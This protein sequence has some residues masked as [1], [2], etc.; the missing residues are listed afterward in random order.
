MVKPKLYSSGSRITWQHFHIDGTMSVR[1]GV[2]WDR[3]PDLDGQ[4]MVCWVVP[5]EAM[6]A[7]FY[8]LIAVGRATRV[9]VH[10]HGPFRQGPS[11]SRRVLFSSDYSGSETGRL[12]AFAAERTRELARV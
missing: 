3:A 7:D 5:D 8:R 9:S 10:V 12:G 2:V 1:S 6:P 11:V 4:D